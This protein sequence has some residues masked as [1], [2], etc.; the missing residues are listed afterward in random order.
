MVGAG[1]FRA[2]IVA[3]GSRLR[4]AGLIAGT[5]GNLSVRVPGGIAITPSGL[6]CGA[7]APEW[8]G[9]HTLDGTPVDAPFAP[10]SELPLHL[11]VHATG[12]VG[13][14]VHTHSA[15]AV[16]VSLLL[17]EVPPIHYYLAS[18]GAAVRVVP[19]APFGSTAL[20]Q[21]AAEALLDSSAALLANHG[22][23]TTG[24]DLAAAVEAALTLEWLCDV[25][26][27]AAAVG[28]PRL[29]NADQMAAARCA[30]AQYRAARPS[31]EFGES[32]MSRFPDAYS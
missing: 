19:Y 26:L 32:E 23:V 5:A 16:A 3:A 17:D 27:R 30:M 2:A 28:S 14:V 31:P 4:A 9:V 11:A 29:L 6:D 7:L 12:T 13:A 24:S 18:F 8:I 21:G 20:A 10:S 22:A 15:A 25:Y 1:D